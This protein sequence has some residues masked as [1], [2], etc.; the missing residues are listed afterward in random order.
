MMD[1]EL[2]PVKNFRICERFEDALQALTVLN[3]HF[4]A[5]DS[6]KALSLLDDDGYV[7]AKRMPD[8]DVEASPGT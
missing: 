4:T 6:M 5:S 2:V 3:R 1:D 8:T 7:L